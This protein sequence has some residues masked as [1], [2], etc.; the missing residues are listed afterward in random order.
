MLGIST[1]FIVRKY[2]NNNLE[3]I[4]FCKLFYLVGGWTWMNLNKKLYSLTKVAILTTSIDT[5]CIIKF[6]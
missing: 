5:K 2:T 1:R 3:T 4:H 6:T